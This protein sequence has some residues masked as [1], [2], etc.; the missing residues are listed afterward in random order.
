M[1]VGLRIFN[2]DGISQI[3]DTAHNLVLIGKGVFNTGNPNAYGQLLNFVHDGPVIFA[4]SAPSGATAI[5]TNKTGTNYEFHAL[6]GK[7]DENVTWYAFS[8]PKNIQSTMGL[9]VFNG[10]GSLVYDAAQKPLRMAHHSSIWVPGTTPPFPSKIKDVPEFQ[11]T[12][13]NGNIYIP[14]QRS[15]RT[16]ASA[17]VHM[18]GY[19]KPSKIKWGKNGWLLGWAF[20]YWLPIAHADG[21]YLQCRR[22]VFSPTTTQWPLGTFPYGTYPYGPQFLYPNGANHQTSWIIDV[23]DY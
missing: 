13:P 15:N 16:Y 17:G 8:Y 7:G 20:F 11:Y 9:R 2:D 22:L 23:T 6:F 12:P 21:V 14:Q 5:V 1:S 19:R 10:N 4:A 3:T 18:I